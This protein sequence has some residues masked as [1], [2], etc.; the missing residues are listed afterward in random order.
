MTIYLF[1]TELIGY[2]PYFIF[3]PFTG[4]LAETLGLKPAQLN[5]Q[6][7]KFFNWPM[8]ETPVRGAAGC[9]GVGG[10]EVTL[11]VPVTVTVTVTGQSLKDQLEEQQAALG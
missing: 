1:S 6:I 7:A 2:L 11:T 8:I 5:N 10:S 9:P 4:R 3:N